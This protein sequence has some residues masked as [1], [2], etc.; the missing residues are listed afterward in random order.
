[1]S[2]N[3]DAAS[4]VDISQAAYKILEYKQGLSKSEFMND[5]KTQSSVLY[6]LLIYDRLGISSQQLSQFCQKWKVAE[7]ALFGSI[8][9]DD[10]RPDSD[11]DFLVSYQPNAK[12]GLFEKMTMQ[13]ELEDLLHRK[14]DLVS[15][16]A[17]IQS[18]NW[19][20]RKNILDS[21]EVIYVA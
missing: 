18:R 2:T 6:Q 8:L 21:A 14:V 13:E 16:Q 17:I 9:R 15:K 11:I 5:D 3:K 4:L 7:L 10:F 20:R 1:M 12:R 19:L